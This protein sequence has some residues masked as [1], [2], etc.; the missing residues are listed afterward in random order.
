MQRKNIPTP[1]IGILTQAIPV[2]YTHAEITS[3]FLYAG[4][5]EAEPDGNKNL[6]VASWLRAVNKLSDKPLKVLG[7]ILDDFLNK[8]ISFSYAGEALHANF[9]DYKDKIENL[10]EEHHLCL[11]EDNLTQINNISIS[12]ETLHE[13]IAKEGLNAIDLECKRS[14]KNISADPWAAVHNAG[15][16]LEAT[17]KVYL[18]RKKIKYNEK[19]DKIPQLWQKIVDDMDIRP[20]NL[21]NKEL[22]KIASGLYKIVDGLMTMRDQFSSSHGKTDEQLTTINIR[23]RV[24]RLN[25]NAAHTLCVYVLDLL[26]I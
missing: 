3:L 23:P 2:Y 11:K 24:A 19:S 22:K 14:L 17:F 1:F 20:E 26:D 12:S 10:L 7:I 6:K 8:E 18:D 25:I 15:C 13:K 5:P 4:A 16:V 21:A 9:L